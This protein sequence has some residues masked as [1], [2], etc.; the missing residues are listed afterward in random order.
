[1]QYRI[2][3]KV[4]SFEKLFDHSVQ[5][6]NNDNKSQSWPKRTHT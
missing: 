1:M 3:G 6:R 2:G 4:F 5:E